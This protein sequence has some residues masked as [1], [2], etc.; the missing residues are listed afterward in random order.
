M[1]SVCGC[2]NECTQ[3]CR[4]DSA[5]KPG[6]QNVDSVDRPVITVV[7]RMKLLR[8]FLSEKYLNHISDLF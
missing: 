4:Y 5:V 7:K 1:R 2:V 3:A 8:S 6:E